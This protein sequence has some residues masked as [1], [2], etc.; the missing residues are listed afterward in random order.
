M[1]TNEKAPPGSQPE[2]TLAEKESVLRVEQDARLQKV[3]A[4]AAATTSKNS[5]QAK[6]PLNPDG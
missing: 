3:K 4:E 1:S 2:G 5:S 6:Q